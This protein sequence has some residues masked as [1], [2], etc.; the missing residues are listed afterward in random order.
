MYNPKG[1]S[2]A[3]SQLLEDHI[4]LVKK[5]A[6]QLKSKLPRNIE[7]DDLIQAGMIGLLD[8]LNRYEDTQQAQFE[9][10]ASVRIRGA[11]LDELRAMD[12]LPR[13]VR[14]NMRKIENAILDL[15]KKLT[16]N[17]TEAEIANAVN[18][19]IQDYHKFLADNSGH[20]LLYLEDFVI[21][22]DDDSYLDH[23]Q[24][25]KN[26]NPLESL[27]ELGFR[28]AL[29]KAIDELPERERLMMALY[30]E[31][32]LNLKEIGAVLDVSESRVSQIH[33]QAIS[34]LRTLLKEQK[35]IGEA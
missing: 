23:Y 9:T 25:D 34:R 16:R 7:E 33:S 32:E 28:D 18:L 21:N 1:R 26:D 8:A 30:Y 24:T 17:P 11:M 2:S 14:E 31:Q 35:W 19:S 4:D 27:L 22:E 20:Q 13:S 29:A 15:Q 6:Y 12:W 10:Y 5:I 3:K